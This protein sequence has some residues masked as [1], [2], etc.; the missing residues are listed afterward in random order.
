MTQ[1]WRNQKSTLTLHHVSSRFKPVNSRIKKK[2]N[3]TPTQASRTDKW[4]L[5]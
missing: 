2:S 4:G 1:L 5:T 3:S